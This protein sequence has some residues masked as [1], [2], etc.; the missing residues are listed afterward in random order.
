M[1]RPA[2]RPAPGRTTRKPPPPSEARTGST[3]VAAHI[4]ASAAS[5][6]L[7]PSRS[8][9]TAAPAVSG[10]PAATIPRICDLAIAGG[11]S[12]RR[13]VAYRPERPLSTGLAPALGRRRG[14]VGTLR[15]RLEAA[16]VANEAHRAARLL[17][18]TH[19]AA[20][21]DQPV[22]GVAQP[23]LRRPRQQR[24]FHLQRRL[25]RSEAGAVGHSEDVRIDG[26]RR[27]AE[28]YVEYDVGGL[29]PDAGERFEG[30]AVT[31][32][33]AAVAF[34][35]RPAQRDH[36]LRLGVE[37]ADGLDTLAQALFA[38][39]Q[40]LRRRVHLTEQRLRRLVDADVGRLRRQH[41]G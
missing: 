17:R 18:L 31:G 20:V 23:S 7:P 38:E 27:L 39:R 32:H 41:D 14:E 30:V 5:T 16:D 4:A 10:C 37:Q 24:G 40:H 28:R 13:M 36:V 3:T 11:R 33:L 25:A 6:A 1:L 8:T 21:Q 15:L 35:Q 12:E 2:S 22:V 29:P 9:A 26:D 34:D 19:V